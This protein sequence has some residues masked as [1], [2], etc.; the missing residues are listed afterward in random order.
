ME[1][2]RRR[3]TRMVPNKKNLNYHEILK[4]LNVYSLAYRRRRADLSNNAAG[5]K[6]HVLLVLRIRD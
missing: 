2:V 4:K 6:N 5:T 3:A 1:T